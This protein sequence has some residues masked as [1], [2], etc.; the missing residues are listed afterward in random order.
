MPL[1]SGKEL[2]ELKD[3]HGMPLDFSL[4]IVCNERKMA[5]DWPSFI[6]AAR[7]AGW[8]DFQTLSQITHAMEHAALPSAYREAVIAGF[9]NYV[10]QNPRSG[11]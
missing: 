9:K 6:E 2:F 10:L 5:V 8:Y 4:D 3:T 1:F 11:E 7:A